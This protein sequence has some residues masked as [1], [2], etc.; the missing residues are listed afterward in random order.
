LADL[1][2]STDRGLWP[3]SD[4]HIDPWRPVARA[5]ISHAHSD[6]ARFDDQTYVRHRAAAPTLHANVMLKAQNVRQG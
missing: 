4:F 6:H 2:V 5:I 3:A 1:I